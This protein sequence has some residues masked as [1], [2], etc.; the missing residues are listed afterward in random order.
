M[1]KIVYKQ[2]IIRE[3]ILR[4]I[5]YNQ[6]QLP[7]FHCFLRCFWTVFDSF[8]V[9]FGGLFTYSDTGITVFYTHF[10]Y[11]FTRI[12]S[13]YSL[14]TY[15]SHRI[16]TKYHS[17]HTQTLLYDMSSIT[18]ITVIYIYYPKLTPKM[19]PYLRGGGQII[20]Q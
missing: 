7:D 14:H 8:L 12:A 15:N 9:S 6:T 16:H 17:L 13:T 5:R 10:Q 18:E 1:I 19:P 20:P 11:I 3:F 2:L 4:K